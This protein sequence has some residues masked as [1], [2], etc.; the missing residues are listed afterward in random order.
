MEEIEANSENDCQGMINEVLDSSQGLE[1]DEDRKDMD[2]DGLVEDGEG[3]DED[4]DEDYNDCVEYTGDSLLVIGEEE[5][6]G[7]MVKEEGIDDEEEEQGEEKVRK[8]GEV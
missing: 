5:E 7:G 1:G 8:E 3:L 2:E 4:E 6:G